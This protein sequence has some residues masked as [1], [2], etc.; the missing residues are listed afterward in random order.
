MSLEAKV[1]V[2]QRRQQLVYGIKYLLPT[3]MGS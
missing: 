3:T 1:K 2:F